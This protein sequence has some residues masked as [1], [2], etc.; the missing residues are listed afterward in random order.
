MK[1]MGGLNASANNS[2]AKQEKKKIHS[3]CTFLDV[4]VVTETVVRC[5][6][7]CNQ[8]ISSPKTPV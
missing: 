6:R 3:L 5:R 1:I 8:R 4:T 7:L 2:I